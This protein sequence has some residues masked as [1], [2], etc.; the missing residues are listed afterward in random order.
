MGGCIA[1]CTHPLEK[2]ATLVSGIQAY[3]AC[4]VYRGSG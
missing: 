4:L 3:I 1:E 2:S